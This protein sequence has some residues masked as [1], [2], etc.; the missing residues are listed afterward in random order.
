MPAPTPTA[1]PVTSAA[2]TSKVS[3]SASGACPRTNV[4]GLFDHHP[5]YVDLV[6]VSRPI[7]RASPATPGRGRT[8]AVAWSEKVPPCFRASPPAVTVAADCAPI[9]AAHERHRATIA[10]AS[11]S[12]MAARLLLGT[13]AACRSTTPS[14]RRS[15]PPPP[16]VFA[17]ACSCRTSRPMMMLR[18]V[19]GARRRAPALRGTTGRT[20]LP[21]RRC[22]QPPRRPRPRGRVGADA[23]IARSPRSSSPAASGSGD[24][25]SLSIAPPRGPR[26]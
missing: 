9:I 18:S 13:L 25:S 26:R 6:D 23:R 2:S 11:T 22:G 4:A 19:S 20:P 3:A 1:A 17:A 15:S 7:A 21:R 8:K 12:S 10:P 24:S 5:G 16:A 14:S